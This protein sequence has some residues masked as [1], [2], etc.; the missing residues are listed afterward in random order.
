[1]TFKN[2]IYGF[3]TFI[4]IFLILLPVNAI[5]QRCKAGA[6]GFGVCIDQN[7]CKKGGG[8]TYSDYCPGEKTNIKCCIKTVTTLKNGTKLPR[9]AVCKNIKNCPKEFNT[10]YY[11]ECP[12][13]NN[14]ILC[15]NKDRDTLITKLTTS[16]RD[17]I[18]NNLREKLDSKSYRY[19]AMIKAAEEMLILNNNNIPKY[20]PKYVAGMLGNIQHE[21]VPGKLES[22]AYSDISNRPPYLKNM[23]LCGYDKYSG[24]NIHNIGIQETRNLSNCGVENNGSFGLGM[25]QWTFDRNNNLLNEYEKVCQNNDNP[26]IDQCAEIEANFMIKE[27]QKT[28][29]KIIYDEWWYEPTA[30]NA[31][32]I[33]CR[34]YENPRNTSEYIV[35]G[36]TAKDI[37][38]NVILCNCSN[39]VKEA[40][41][42]SNTNT[43]SISNNITDVDSEVCNCDSYEKS[44]IYFKL[45]ELYKTSYA[46]AD[47]NWNQ[48]PPDRKDEIDS[49]LT[50]LIVECLDP[51]REIYGDR[52]LVTSGYRNDKVNELVTKNKDSDSQHNKA[53]AADLQPIPFQND[54]LIELYYAIYEFNNYDQFI[55]EKCRWAHVSYRNSENNRHKILYAYENENRE[56]QYVY[57]AKDDF[58]TYIDGCIN[59]LNKCDSVIYSANIFNATESGEDSICMFES[60]S[61]IDDEPQSDIETISDNNL[62]SDDN[63]GAN[64]L[65]QFSFFSIFMIFTT[66]LIWHTHIIF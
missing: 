52:I 41:I 8:T 26:S 50:T 35:R 47:N 44:P 58:Q 4:H 20:D 56:T 19:K 53:E 33:L 64:N 54:K 1:M 38:K 30:Y 36:N 15:L 5:N 63:S 21:G 48:P 43:K 22:W 55:I 40:S 65:K 31:G 57:V 59:M 13:D 16:G 9:K 6:N 51:I 18:I 14:I 24:K 37:Y 46:K 12:G 60:N 27:L 23:E 45:S 39:L 32:D 25:I 10:Q 2:K 42:S 34:Y 62:N 7:E 29:Y 28:N 61:E 17:K 3:I 11:G 49:K 66:I